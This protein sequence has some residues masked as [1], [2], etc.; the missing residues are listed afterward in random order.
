[1]GL[2]SKIV[3]L[4]WTKQIKKWYVDKG[5]I[6]TEYGDE[7]EVKVEDLTNGS[8]VLVDIQCNECG[9]LLKNRKWYSYKNTV[10]NNGKYYCRKCSMKL[11]G[12]E[13]VREAQLEKGKTFKQWCLE[14]NRQDL[15]DR[16]DYELN[17]NKPDNIGLHTHIRIWFK[18]PR[19]IHEPEKKNIGNFIKEKGSIE[20]K[21]CNSFA[22]W[23]VDTLCKDFLEKYWDYEK[24]IQTDPWKIAKHSRYCVWIKCQEKDYHGSYF[25]SCT[26][27]SNGGNRCPY[28]IN[29]KVHKLDSLGTLY[30]KSLGVWSNKNK[31]SPYEYSPSTNKKAWWKC[32]D[33]KHKD[34]ERNIYN[35]NIVDFRCPRCQFSQG[36]EAISSYLIN[37]EMTH[38]PQK[39]FS[40]LIGLGGGLL[41]YD[42]YLLEYNLL[43]EYQ[44]QQHEKFI[45]WFHKSKKDFE[46]QQE[47]DRRKRE[48]AKNNNIKLLEIWYWN[49]D[50]IEEILTK[51][52]NQ[53]MFRGIDLQKSCVTIGIHVR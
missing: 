12:G 29:R 4:K 24:N 27:F 5:Y 23:G 36:E 38:I 43:I 17:I 14:N 48:Y 33:G 13:R 34:F 15:L 53:D 37:N 2:I 21:K 6:F 35:S 3:K 52:L 9:K 18:C 40:G 1:M 26:N 25:T 31:K 47:H 32:P 41:S 16:W 45:S 30:P 28:C 8:N 50:K 11:Y 7:F 19:K 22:Q 44:G 39:T 46:R 20:C 42:F 10:K 49:F 51:I